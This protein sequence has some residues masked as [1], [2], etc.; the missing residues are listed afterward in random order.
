MPRPLIKRGMGA[1]S[2]KEDTLEVYGSLLNETEKILVRDSFKTICASQQEID[3]FTASHLQVR[4]CK[5]IQY[6]YYIQKVYCDAF[7]LTGTIDPNRI[8]SA[9]SVV[10]APDGT[11]TP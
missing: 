11:V 4:A 7:G 3:R 10:V 8:L 2:S 1:R 6:S 9:R 5:I